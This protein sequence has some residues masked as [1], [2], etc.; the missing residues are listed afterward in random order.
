MKKIL[1]LLVGLVALLIIVALMAP[2][3]ISADTYKAEL[4]SKVEAAT[5]R[6]LT[7]SG[8]LSFKLFPV[9]GIKA[10]Q[11]TLSNP[12]G[13]DEKTQFIT[14]SALNIE[15]ALMPLLS[16]EIVVK[17]FILKDPVINLRSN[18]DGRKNWDFS[19][20]KQAPVQEPQEDANKRPSVQKPGEQP[21]Q[22]RPKVVTS[23]SLPAGLMLNNVKLENGTVV[24]TGGCCGPQTT[25]SHINAN[26]EV[27]SLASAAAI[28]GS[29]DWNGKTIK[30]KAGLGTLKSFLQ[31]QKG[32]LNA[33]V[34][35]D[36]FDVKMEGAYDKG[37][38]T[39]N[40]SIKAT[41]LAE[42]A[43]WLNPKTKL[44]TPAK[45]ALKLDSELRCGTNY[46][47]LPNLKLTLDG[48]DAT[49]QARL[50]FGDARPS[51]DLSLASD[52][53]DFNPF[54]PAPEHAGVTL[55]NDAV[56]AE[57]RFSTA[58]IDVSVLKAFN[59][60]IAIKTGSINFHKFTIGK[61]Q[62]DVRVQQGVMTAGINNAVLYDGTGSF[63][64]NVNANLVPAMFDTNFALNS[65]AIAPLLKDA[66]NV[67][68]LTGT[69]SVSAALKSNLQ[70]MQSLINGLDGSGKV[71][72][73]NGEIK[74][75]N[76]DDM[77]H[78][79]GTA[80]AGANSMSSESK[81]TAFSDISGTFTIVQGVITNK[82][83]V[84][85]LRDLL[86]N[87]QGTV[88]LPAW[89]VNYHVVPKLTK[90]TKDDKGVSTTKAGLPVPVMIE[91]SLE[92]PQFRPDLNAV[93]QNAL[94]DPAQLK[95]QLRNNREILKDQLKNPKDAVK[96]LK[97][98]LGGGR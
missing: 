74:H 9:A 85:Q 16:K 92:H 29:A 87:G 81:S 55:V 12:P 40:Q 30:V 66:A 18:K 72:L 35:T 1:K 73:S 67:E 60:T 93:L 78:N 82:D 69:A 94:Q 63:A 23:K 56:A 61:T 57:G 34:S 64:L 54:L 31:D 3:F 10:E 4:I 15:V 13:F 77:L 32:E 91:G 47:N 19:A 21:A 75:F 38:F 49:G 90:T 24:Y 28:D 33:S 68:S 59:A 41:S 20:P 48:V 84:G 88:S 22:P 71:K 95:E 97:N 39:G 7:I 52:K 46:C 11:V 27:Q 76:I 53:L 89:S 17:D 62:L 51:V 58:P 2:M 44:P 70:N 80:F 26:V 98:L 86:V 36:I 43:L 8:P 14:L 79:V 96:S 45:L 5:G 50:G 65:V 25:V 6:K 83:L 37:A 42:L